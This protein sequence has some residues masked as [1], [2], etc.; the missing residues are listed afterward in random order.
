MSGTVQAAEAMALTALGWIAADA[1]QLTAFLQAGGLDPA[2]LRARAA[3]P[4]MLAAVLDFVLAEDARVLDFAVHV[5]V[6]PDRVVAAR[7][8]LPGG[9]DPHWT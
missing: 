7:A 3:D 9:G 5:G 2:D 1:E 6:R 8:L 4:E